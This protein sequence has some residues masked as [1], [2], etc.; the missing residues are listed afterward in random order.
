[1]AVLA[2]GW[3]APRVVADPIT[4]NI[5]DLSQRM[6]IG[7]NNQGQ[8]GLGIPASGFSGGDPEYFDQFVYPTTT[9]IYTSLGPN[10]GALSPPNP[11]GPIPGG[12]NGSTVPW[13]NDSG[14]STGV[15]I[16]N[17]QLVANVS[18]GGAQQQF[19][20][21]GNNGDNWTNPIAINN[22][23]QVVGNAWFPNTGGSHAFLYSGGVTQDLGTLGGAEHG[24]C[25]Q[26]ERCGR[27]MGDG[28]EQRGEPGRPGSRLRL[29][30]WHHD[31]PD[32]GLGEQL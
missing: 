24:G 23:G 16:V 9:S 13:I 31:G 14:A 27:R 5:T 17:N 6:P 11:S 25:D 15:T 26:Q 4:Y 21:Y 30:E 2:L 22:A 7:I 3:V 10:A 19:G 12:G 28:P 8:V 1:M 18:V 29:S 32:P 20:P